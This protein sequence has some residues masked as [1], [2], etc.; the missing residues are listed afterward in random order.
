MSALRLAH[1][2]P[3]LFEHDMSIF[4]SITVCGRSALVPRI[5]M[6]S[7]ATPQNADEVG[8]NELV[9]NTDGMRM[10]RRDRSPRLPVRANEQNKHH[11]LEPTLLVACARMALRRIKRH[12]GRFW[13][14]R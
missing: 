13:S 3:A 7:L 6:V 4:R 11:V 12:W 2:L 10:G 9:L 14:D 8:S 5:R 1:S